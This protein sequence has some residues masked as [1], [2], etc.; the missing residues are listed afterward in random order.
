[1]EKMKILLDHMRYNIGAHENNIGARKNNIWM[2]NRLI[3]N[4]E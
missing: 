2:H 4:E 1:M 3:I